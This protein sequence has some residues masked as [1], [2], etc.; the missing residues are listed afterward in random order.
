VVEERA[1]DY[2]GLP[3]S[4]LARLLA[5]GRGGQVLLSHVTQE[6]VREHL[7]RGAELRDLG[8]HRLKDLNQPEHIFQ[9]VTPDLVADFPPLNTLDIRRTNLPAQPTPLIG[10]E[11]EIADVSALLCRTDVHLV[12]LSGPGG[13]GKTRL[14]LQVA[15]E[16]IDGFADGVY[17]VDLAPIRDP[18]L[19]ASAIAETL[20]VKESGT[21]PL[22]QQLRTYL[23]D[24]T[25]LLLLDNF[26]QVLDAA[27]LVAELLTG[28]PALT[29]LVTSREMLHVRGE[30]E[31]EVPPLAVPNRAHLPSLE[32][33]T[34]YAAVQ[35]F[36]ARA[37]AAK[38]DF[39]VTNATAPAVAEICVQLDG[40]P[41]AIELAAARVKLFGPEA[42]LAQLNQRLPFLTDG[43]RDLP[44]RQQ[45]LRATI[46]WSYALLDAAEQTLFRRLGVF[47]G[48]CTSE[49]AEA[50][51]N[52]EDDLPLDAV[53]GLA[54][55]VDKSLLKQ[56]EGTGGAPRFTCS[57]RFASM[58]W[59]DWKRAGS[60][61]CCGECT[62]SPIWR[63]R[64]GLNVSS[65]G[66]N[67][68]PG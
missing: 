5:A 43:P 26:E 53:G 24:K 2:V 40:L 34:Q 4:R 14:A 57:R 8:T 33:L 65:P 18:A 20:G 56:A 31:Y 45:T 58:P 46:D 50:V 47:V 32:H 9:L 60:Y 67:N 21:Q 17:F 25:V 68:W 13:T 30:Y 52:A 54:A 15:A 1:G 51:C 44:L 23:H 11:R 16:L 12:T 38:R 37:Q 64:S 48:G 36:I 62:W 3:L 7:P 41:L 59:N 19:V 61:R 29:V 63:L 42:L 27:P 55:L 35:L 6:L 28:A 66:L 10:R 22:V 49:A 39:A